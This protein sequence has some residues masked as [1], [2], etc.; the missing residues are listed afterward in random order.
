MFLP[1]LAE[2]LGARIVPVRSGAGSAVCDTKLLDAAAFNK[3]EVTAVTHNSQWV[4]P[5]ALFVAINGDSVDGHKFAAAAEQAGAVAVL[6][7]GRTAAD[8]SNLPYL[9]VPNA[10]QALADAAVALTGDPSADLRVIGITGTDGKTTTS[11]LT[12]YILRATGT[13]VGMLSTAGYELADG[14]LQQF[15]G[16]FTTPE[17]PQVQQILGEMRDQ[18]AT[19]AVIES[20][21]HALLMER[22]R[23]VKWDVAIW[24]HISPEHLNTHGGMEGY[25]ADKRKL[26]EAAPFAVLNADDPWCERLRGI[27]PEESTYGVDSDAEWRAL[28][29]TE[30]ASGIDFTLQYP[31]DDRE[32][33]NV[34]A[35]AQTQA[36]LPMLGRYN[37]YNALAA[38]A[39]VNRLGVSVPDAL[40][41]LREFPG[42]PGRMQTV[43]E[44]QS[45]IN[46][47]IDFAHA[48]KSLEK[49]LQALREVTE[50]E[51]WV[52]V[53]AAGGTRDPS[54]REP[55]GRIATT[56]ADHVVF[57]ED[58]PYFTPV[59][60]IVAQMTA[61]ADAAG[62]SNYTVIED[63]TAAINFAVANA[64][65]GAV[66]LLAGKGPES[67]IERAHGSAPWS[68]IAA[69]KT[70]LN[71]RNSMRG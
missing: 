1:E 48:E 64:P 44:P 62:N 8:E 31:G 35:F 71:L 9:Q 50:T 13:S 70:A 37:A 7:E 47:V 23:G 38:I 69:A 63:R 49:A 15:E 55:M 45:D 40:R 60:E 27:A 19:A 14:E 59:Q 28:D 30:T 26:I 21:S 22:V 17:A 5:G 36:H 43:Q 39:A 34:D 16:R 32:A 52:V 2:L 57:T 12:R 6:G 20:S 58:D 29:I 66:V 4:T 53:G 46:V 68:E 33:D 10:R 61:G 51:L 3:T 11:W 54:K 25:F 65:A 41:A 24:T 67:T 56:I 42:V 18:G